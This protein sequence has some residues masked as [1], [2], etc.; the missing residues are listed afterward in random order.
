MHQH[1]NDE[2]HYS[3][4]KALEY[5]ESILPSECALIPIVPLKKSPL[6][7]QWNETKAKEHLNDDFRAHF[8]DQV[9]IGLVTGD[10]SSGLCFI[11]IDHDDIA[12]T[13]EKQWS[14]LQTTMKVR[15]SRGAKWLLYC[16][17]GMRGKKL[18]YKNKMVGEL[19]ATGQQGVLAGLHP[20]TLKPY[21]LSQI[22]HG[23]AT[24]NPED[25]SFLNSLTHVPISL[26]NHKRRR[27]RRK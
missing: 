27:L 20:T 9:G 14:I 4:L 16:P 19:L 13:L 2:T 6:L 17:L 21:Q 5:L 3:C 25:L 23:I 8:K 26:G 11:D 1:V 10:A 12:D 18:Y 24:L 22:E 7:K 15:G